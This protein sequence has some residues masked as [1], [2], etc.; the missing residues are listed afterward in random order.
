MRKYLLIFGFG[1]LFGGEIKEG[2]VCYA[3]ENYFPILQVMLDSVKAF[4]N[5][6]VVAFGVNA[7]IPFSLEEYPFLIKKRVNI[8]T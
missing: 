7:D 8:P 1:A 4:S 5:R 6:P 2:F 3:T